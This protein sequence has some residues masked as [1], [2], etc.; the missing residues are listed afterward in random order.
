MKEK[1]LTNAHRLKYIY[2]IMN[3]LQ[4]RVRQFLRVKKADT[5]NDAGFFT[6]KLVVS[7]C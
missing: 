6:F 4:K 7:Y 5:F 1:N 2:L 3:Y